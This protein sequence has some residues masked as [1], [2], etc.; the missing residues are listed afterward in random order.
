MLEAQAEKAMNKN[1]PIK[2]LAPSDGCQSAPNTGRTPTPLTGTAIKNAM[3][4]NP[5]FGAAAP[6][7]VA[8]PALKLSNRSFVG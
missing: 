2:L 5:S 6:S 8:R 3:P 7:L 4:Q 1:D